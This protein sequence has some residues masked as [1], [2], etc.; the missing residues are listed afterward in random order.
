[1]SHPPGHCG[2]APKCLCLPTPDERDPLGCCN[3]GTALVEAAKYALDELE[4]PQP[5]DLGRHYVAI[6]QLKRALGLA[7]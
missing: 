4:G 1:M 7:R 5:G 2:H 3:C 6:A